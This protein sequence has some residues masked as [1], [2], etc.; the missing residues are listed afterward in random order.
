MTSI[1]CEHKTLYFHFCQLCSESIIGYGTSIKARCL[2]ST[3]PRF[4]NRLGSFLDVRFPPNQFMNESFRSVR[5][6]IYSK[7]P[8]SNRPFPL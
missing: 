1:I 4:V 7:E 3:H 2:S 6:L 8:L 5:T